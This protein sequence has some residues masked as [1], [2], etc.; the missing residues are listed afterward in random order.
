[1]DSPN[2]ETKEL[3]IGKAMTV[4]HFLYDTLVV[5]DES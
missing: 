4:K 2:R 1:M 5:T 3:A